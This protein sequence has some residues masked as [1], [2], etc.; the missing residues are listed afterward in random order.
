MLDIIVDY[1]GTLGVGGLLVAV[2]IEALGL[3]FPG[4]IMVI[5]AG[6][7][8]G[9]GKIGLGPVIGA[10]VLGFS[11]GA[12]TAFY[13]G[14]NVGEPLMERYG[15]YL[16]ITPDS[17][18]QAQR[19]LEQ[20]SAA[21]ILIGRFIPMV[22]N[23]TPYIAGMSHL[24]WHKFLFYNSI[25]VLLWSGFHISLGLFF[26]HNWQHLVAETQ[27]KLLFI[28]PGLLILY[29]IIKY[30]QLNRKKKIMK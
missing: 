18:C 11:L 21:F 2:Y 26:G 8:A 16:H 29:M 14:K 28:A 15:S 27:S 30:L 20:S 12:S 22:S 5:L 1:L 3:P 23:L 10:T 13:L 24:T 4:G 17:F 7:L 19:W 6:V 25:F 9:Q